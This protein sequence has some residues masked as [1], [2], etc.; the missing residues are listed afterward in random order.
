[1]AVDKGETFEPITLGETG[2]EGIGEVGAEEEKIETTDE[3]SVGESL[4]GAGEDPH[5]LDEG[6]ETGEGRPMPKE[7][8]GTLAPGSRNEKGVIKITL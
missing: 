2:E 6:G 3:T 5:H 4:I 8:Y 7:L 1:M